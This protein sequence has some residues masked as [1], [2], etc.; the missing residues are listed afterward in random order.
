MS[1]VSGVLGDVTS[2][3]SS[4]LEAAA[5]GIK[6]LTSDAPEPPD[7]SQVAGAF[8]PYIRWAQALAVEIGAY[9]REVT[10]VVTNM[11]DVSGILG[12]VTSLV[13]SA[14]EAAALGAAILA[15]DAPEPPDANRVAGAFKPYIRWAQ[16]VAVAVSAYAREVNLTIQNMGDVSGVIGDVTSLIQQVLDAAGTAAKL[17][18]TPPELPSVTAT[19]SAFIR[20]IDWA[21]D[22]ATQT[23]QATGLVLIAQNSLAAIGSTLGDVIGVIENG[24]KLPE[25]LRAL[26]SFQGI[27]FTIYGPK[28]DLLIDSLKE[29]LQRFTLRAQGAN[30]TEAAQ[31]AVAAF[32]TGAGQA[33]DTL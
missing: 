1:D 23:A 25:L 5:L 18:A 19:S 16:A 33:M 8:Q 10:L 31:K 13:S 15:S 26:S 3:V 14:L 20:L 29:L 4:A 12:D 7:A 9:A 32:S 28:F 11:S 24:L 30:F 2:L 27:N 22:V 6:L 17:I 21:Q